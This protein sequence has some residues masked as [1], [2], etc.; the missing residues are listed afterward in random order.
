M[1][2]LL[3]IA[4]PYIGKDKPSKITEEND[5]KL[6]IEFHQD[7]KETVLLRENEKAALIQ[8]EIVNGEVKMELKYYVKG[9]LHRDKD[10][11]SH[12]IYMNGKAVA[13]YYYRKGKL[14]RLTGAAIMENFN[15]NSSVR[16]WY[17]NGKKHRDDGAAYESKIGSETHIIYYKNDKMHRIGGPA[18][19]RQTWHYTKEQWFEE[20]VFIREYDERLD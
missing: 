9:K 10:R 7:G 3:A 14:H 20:G 15:A 16:V 18:W 2:K 12:W 13:T 5:G 11:P 19:T 4:T 1:D 17:R 6:V 8:V